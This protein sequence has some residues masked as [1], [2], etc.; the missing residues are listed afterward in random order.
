MEHGCVLL[1]WTV[2]YTMLACPLQVESWAMGFGRRLR[3][4]GHWNGGIR[5]RLVSQSSEHFLLL[6]VEGLQAAVFSAHMAW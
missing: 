6:T 3:S 5:M 4:P 2:G 1:G